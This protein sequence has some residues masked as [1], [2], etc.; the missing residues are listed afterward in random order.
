MQAYAATH[1]CRTHSDQN[2]PATVLRMRYGAEKILF[3]ETA[4]A[5]KFPVACDY[6]YS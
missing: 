6:L 3:S 1:V 5:S 4:A 2:I